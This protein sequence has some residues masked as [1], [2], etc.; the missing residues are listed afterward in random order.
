MNSSIKTSQIV[1]ALAAFTSAGSI[2]AQSGPTLSPY[3]IIDVGIG[4][5]TYGG[6][7]GKVDQGLLVA[8]Y[9]T[10][11]T[12]I[13]LNGSIDLNDGLKVIANVQGRFNIT[14]GA[15]PSA[16]IGAGKLFGAAANAGFTGSFG[17]V[18]AGLNWGPYDSSFGTDA[19]QY[20]LF[21]PSAY[22]YS[23]A[24]QIDYGTGGY[25]NVKNSV[26]YSS[27]SINGFDFSVIYAPQGDATPTSSGTTYVAAGINYVGEKFKLNAAAERSPSSIASTV[28]TTSSSNYTNAFHAGASYTFNSFTI[29]GSLK[30]AEAH[31]DTTTIKDN[32]YGF[33][34][35]YVVTEKSK[36]AVGWATSTTTSQGQ[37]DGKADSTGIMYTYSAAK[38]LTYYA[39]ANITQSNWLNSPSTYVTTVYGTGV[40]LDL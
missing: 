7:P 27:P 1:V 32:G 29:D 21:S 16:G 36:V 11:T 17:T 15:L 13:G 37:I 12:G 8:S 2:F 39:G 34:L 40:R 22:A 30:T 23:T 28:V 35:S 4:S 31:G 10:P 38:G 33:G 3:A 18:T 25:G 26:K 6:A 24:A 9:S 19:L 5:T 14:D 20:G